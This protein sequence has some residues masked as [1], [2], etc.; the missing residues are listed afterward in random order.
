MLRLSKIHD[1]T[2]LKLLNILEVNKILIIGLPQ[3]FVINH[4]VRTM[5]YNKFM[6][7][8]IAQLFS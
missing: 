7:N 2:W 1:S 4:P 5:H 8:I 6:T 3:K